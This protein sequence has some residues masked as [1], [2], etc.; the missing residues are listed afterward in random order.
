MN[1]AGRLMKKLEA[2]FEA[3]ALATGCKVKYTWR[4]IGITK[5]VVQN[6][7]L[8]DHY[9]H[10]MEKYGIKFP[11]EDEQIRAGGGSTDMGNVSYEMPCI[12]PTYGI[13]TTASNHT[14]EFTAAAKTVAAHKDTITASKCLAA[15]GVEVL[16]NEDYYNS[17]QRNFKD[18]RAKE[19]DTADACRYI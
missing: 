15:T 3:A 16:M 8:A 6:K 4:E 7:P 9:A 12:H 14:I 13:H 19:M 5:D 10:H 2:C 17:V 1:Q 18:N 11:S